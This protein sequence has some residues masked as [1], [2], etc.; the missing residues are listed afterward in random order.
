MEPRGSFKHC[1]L[2]TQVTENLPLEETC[3][4]FIFNQEHSYGKKK[5]K[6]CVL[7]NTSSILVLNKKN[8]RIYW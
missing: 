5:A 3:A 6:P 1:N 2:V 8:S 4:L 7:L